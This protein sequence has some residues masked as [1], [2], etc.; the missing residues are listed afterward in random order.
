MSWLLDER[1]RVLGTLEGS[2]PL[3]WHIPR[4]H[5]A[6]VTAHIA[7][8]TG[9]GP[10]ANGAALE[11]DPEGTVRAVVELSPWRPRLLVSPGAIVALPRSLVHDARLAR[12]QRLELRR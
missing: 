11:L 6:L 5:G 1:G 12:G 2:G 10:L 9:L 3:L 4:D 8:W 7:L